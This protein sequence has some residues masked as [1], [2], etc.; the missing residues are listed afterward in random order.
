M[1]Y[2]VKYRLEFSDVLGNGKK[3]EILQD[4]YTGDV[5][6]MIG[7]GNP[8]EIVWDEDDDF[9]EPIIGSSCNVNLM[10]TDD[11]QYD[12]FWEADEFEYKVVVY[13]AEKQVD[14]FV[15]R[16]ESDRSVSITSG[17]ATVVDVSN[18]RIEVPEC[19]ES[20]FEQQTTI[21]TEFRQRVQEDGGIVDKLSCIGEVITDSVVKN[22][23][24]FWQGFLY[25]DGFQQS[26]GTKPFPLTLKALD[27]LGTLNAYD[28]PII[29]RNPPRDTVQT[30]PF[31]SASTRGEYDHVMHILNNLNL[32]MDLYWQGD[33]QSSTSNRITPLRYWV[34]WENFTDKDEIIDAKKALNLILRQS[35]SRI[36]QAYGRWYVVKNSKYL[37]SVLQDQYYDQS[38]YQTALS[39]G[40]NEIIDFQVYSY[41]DYTY[42]LF[43]TPYTYPATVYKGKADINVTR[44]VKSDLLPLN[45]DLAVEFLPPLKKVLIETD[46]SEYNQSL[47]RY[48]NAKNFEWGLDTLVPYGSISNHSIV[49]TGV[50]SYKLTNFTTG[51]SKIVALECG[52]VNNYSLLY[53]IYGDLV[54]S[55]EYYIESTN[56]SPN[57]EIYYVLEIKAEDI[58]GTTIY[59][60]YDEA[61][62]SFGSAVVYNQIDIDASDELNTWNK[63]NVKFPEDTDYLF[64]DPQITIKF[65]FPK[66][67]TSSG[68]SAF[69]IDNVLVYQDQGKPDTNILDADLGKNSGIYDMELSSVDSWRQGYFAGGSQDDF[70]TNAQE[71]LNDYRAFVPRYEGTFYNNNS[72]P[73][74]PLAKPFINFG[75]E[76]KGKQAEMIDG[77]KYNVKANEYSLIMHTSN[78]DP[79]ESVTFIN[80]T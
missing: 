13:Y 24:V 47:R 48:F 36:F 41:E 21:S 27:G 34:D 25:V 51:T 33:S 80:K 26:F 72:K 56:T 70:Q 32:E 4:G 16:V 69:Y 39:N 73:I 2:E 30:P 44:Q 9:Y 79:D 3:V 55:F 18:G 7:T 66:L 76:F 62:K 38:V 74:T 65:Y 17:G 63:Y 20:I 52:G 43:G 10:V 46:V 5:L 15:N 23:E 6:P 67:N 75:D 78:N 59:R 61:N 57:Y 12:N 11:V 8:V 58:Y 68:Y 54:T 49:S 29:G 53:S 37:D 35:N 22:Y 14:E 50:K 64:Y 71:I 77:M 19:I 40:Q 45:N 1:A 60:R 42:T 28:A 31:D